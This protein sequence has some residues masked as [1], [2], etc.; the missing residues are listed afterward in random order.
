MLVKVADVESSH[1]RM[2][3]VFCFIY[4]ALLSTYANADVDTDTRRTKDSLVKELNEDNWDL[5]LT[6]EWMVEL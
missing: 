2:G 1:V 6:G 3:P 4:V 5:M